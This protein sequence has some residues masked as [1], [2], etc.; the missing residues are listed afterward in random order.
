[1]P[2]SDLRQR[3]LQPEIMDQA[4]LDPGEHHQALKAIS[5]INRVSS[6]ARILWPSIRDLARERLGFLCVLAG[7]IALGGVADGG[8]VHS[9]VRSSLAAALL[10]ICA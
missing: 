7:F 9:C 8:F 6:S 1:M 3:H 5:R 10:L 2:A 4:G